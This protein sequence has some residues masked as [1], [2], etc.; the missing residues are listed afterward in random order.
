LGAVE[1]DY[2]VQTLKQTH[3]KIGVKDSAAEI[4]GLDRNTLRARV[5]K[6]DI[7]KP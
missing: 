1:R 5:R 7:R 3:W 4:L 6:L 2:I